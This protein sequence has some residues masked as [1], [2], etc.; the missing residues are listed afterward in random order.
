MLEAAAEKST[1]SEA[2][3]V[4]V[5]AEQIVVGEETEKANIEAEK[6]AVMAAEVGKVQSEAEADLAKAEP[7]VAAAMAALDTIDKKD[8]SVCK[9]MTKPPPGVDDIFAAVVVLVAGVLP[10]VVTAKNGK[11]KENDNKYSVNVVATEDEENQVSAKLN[12]DTEA[13][14]MDMKAY[15]SA[16][17]LLYSLCFLSFVP[18]Y[19][20]HIL[21]N[22]VYIV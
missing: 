21:P 6:V 14:T 15:Y 3:A 4:R 5:S 20:I 8:L 11:V 13:Q 7:A 16:S 18:G 17:K 9:T 19:S 10:S 12:L 1:V 22:V 2:I